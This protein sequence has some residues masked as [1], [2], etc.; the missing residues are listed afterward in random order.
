MLT[1]VI[2]VIGSSE[3]ADDCHGLFTFVSCGTKNENFRHLRRRGISF[4]GERHGERIRTPRACGDGRN[5]K[6]IQ[7]SS[8]ATWSPHA[9]TS[10]VVRDT[11]AR[12]YRRRRRRREIR[13]GLSEANFFF[14][15]RKSLA[16][17][18]KTFTRGT[19]PSWATWP[20]P[21]GRWPA[22]RAF[23]HSSWSSAAAS[24]WSD[25]Y[26]LSSR[27]GAFSRAEN[28]EIPRPGRIPP[29]PLAP[30]PVRERL[31][32]HA[33]RILSCCYVVAVTMDLVELN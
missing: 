27:T 9:G 33:N 12:F 29:S 1:V 17:K 3:S 8:L 28:T 21:D 6:R 22:G 32:P 2:T 19:C 16:P 26:S 10:A 13:S 5:R 25:S 14:S 18:W 24:R 11:F 31:K 20:V 7:F 23:C 4:P 15:A 30:P